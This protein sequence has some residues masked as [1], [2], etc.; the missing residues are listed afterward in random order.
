LEDDCE[1]VAPLV[2]GFSSE[3]LVEIFVTAAEGAGANGS[4]EVIP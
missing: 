1:A 2:E 4:S 3:I